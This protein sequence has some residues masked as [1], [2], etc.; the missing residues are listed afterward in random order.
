MCIYIVHYGCMRIL[1]CLVN[2]GPSAPVANL[3]V[4]VN[5]N[6]ISN[7]VRISWDHIP[8]DAWNGD[9]GGYLVSKV[10]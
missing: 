5:F 7:L 10:C 4:A 9:F 6:N 1:C 3:S 2:A 8:D